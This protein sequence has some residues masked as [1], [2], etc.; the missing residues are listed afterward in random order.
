MLEGLNSGLDEAGEQ[1]S[2]LEDGGIDITQT[3]H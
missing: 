1:I 3:E 2:K